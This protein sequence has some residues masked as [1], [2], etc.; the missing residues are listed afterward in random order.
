MRITIECSN[1][2]NKFDISVSARKTL[3]FRDNLERRNFYYQNEKLVNGKMKEFEIHC[4]KC[5]NWITL[6]V[7]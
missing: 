4:A 1:C 2:G 6:S 5:N 3:Q 7:D